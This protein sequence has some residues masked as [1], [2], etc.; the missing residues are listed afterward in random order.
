MIKDSTTTGALARARQHWE[1]LADFRARRNRYK[2]FTYGDQWCDP[3]LDPDGH[4]VSEGTLA[5]Q[6]GKI[7]MTN[8]LI[9]RLIKCVVGHFR[10]NILPENRPEEPLAGV[11]T[12]NCLDELDSRLLEEF[13]I[14]GFAVQRV[15]S[16]NRPQGG[17]VWV[18]NVQPDRFFVNRLEDPRGFDIEFIGMLHDMSFREVAMRFGRGNRSLTAELATLYKG[19]T[20]TEFG[21]TLSGESPGISF[22]HAAE[23]KCRVVEIWRCEVTE[24]FTIHDPADSS[25]RHASA[26]EYAR[27]EAENRRR[28]KASLPPLAARWELTPGWRCMWLAPD[29]TLLDSYCAPSHPFAVKLYPLTDGEVHSL[30]EDVIDQQKVVNRLITLIDHLIGVSAKGTLLFPVDQLAPQWDAL[31]VAKAWSRPGAIIPYRPSMASSAEPHQI[32]TN[33]TN[34]GARELLEL[35]MKMFEDVS[36]ITNALM[37]K[38]NSASV[39]VARYE[40]EVKNALVSISDLLQSFN[41][42]RAARDNKILA[43]AE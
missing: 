34:I 7:P 4:A 8:N 41:S 42:L 10:S 35:E 21:T 37:G 13:L 22:S 11:Y 5:R 19:I 15:V 3:A 6:Q 32:A 18:D 26:D 16:E 9:R 2:R 20:D 1:A 23:G 36:G 31:M 24:R 17:G 30:V 33:A 38:A 40:S 43:A 25:L 27:I 39:G 12:A 28:R 14:S 29:G